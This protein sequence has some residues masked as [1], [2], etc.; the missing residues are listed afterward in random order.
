MKKNCYQSI[1]VTPNASQ[2]QIERA[3]SAKKSEL[4]HRL[5]HGEDTQANL[6]ALRECYAILKNPDKRDAYDQTLFKKDTTTPIPNPQDSATASPLR[7]CASCGKTISRLA[8]ACPHCGHPYKPEPSAATK[9]PQSLAGTL[10]TVVLASILLGA[11]ISMC[12]STSS[13]RVESNSLEIDAYAMCQQYVKNSLKAPST[14]DFPWSGRGTRNSIGNYV[15][16][17]Y[18]DAENSFGAKLRN[19]YTCEVEHIGGD[20]WRLINLDIR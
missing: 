14:A 8:L 11:I 12:D 19:H 18:V 9:K 16:V 15:V 3:Y 13:T 6:D 2:E 10:A 1:G 4:G 5:E 7:E 17:S 20:R